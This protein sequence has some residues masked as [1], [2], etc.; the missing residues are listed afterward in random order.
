[1]PGLD[2]SGPLG[3]G[4]MTGGGRGLCG[5]RT[6]LPPE[7]RG[8]DIGRRLY[9]RRG[10][11]GRGGRGFGGGAGFN[12]L[13]ERQAVLQQPADEVETLRSQAQQLQQSLSAIQERLDALTK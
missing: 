2:R 9:C 10:F 1:M 7:D 8:T 6:T 3:Q 4:A 11:R 12:Q 5:S 13:N